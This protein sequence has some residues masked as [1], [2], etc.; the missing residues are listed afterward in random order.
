M[1]YSGAV[2][3]SPG[4]A[5]MKNR[6]NS[7]SLTEEGRSALRPSPLAFPEEA[8]WVLFVPHGRLGRNEAGGRTR[9]GSLMEVE[10]A[11]PAA[12]T[13]AFPRRRFATG[14][15]QRVANLNLE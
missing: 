13:Q 3:R 1:P 14:W 12:S 5:G 7:L 9:F 2:L 8:S 4:Q 15:A 10:R 6:N 11:L